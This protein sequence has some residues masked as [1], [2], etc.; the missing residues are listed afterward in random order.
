VRLWGKIF[1]SK[2]N[3]I[4]VETEFR[5]G[6]VEEE[7]QTPNAETAANEAEAEADTEDP[8][9]GAP[10]PKSKQVKKLSVEKQS[11]VNK[12]IYF[13]CSYGNFN[14]VNI[15]AGGEWT[16]LPDVIPEKLQV[17]RQINKMFTGDLQTRIHSYPVFDGDEAQYLRCQIARISAATVISPSNYYIP[18][19]EEAESDSA[20]TNPPIIINAE[21]EG[22]SNEQ[23]LL[24]SN[25]VHHVP[26]ILPQ[27]R[28]NWENPFVSKRD[29]EDEEAEEDE[30][31]EEEEEARIEPETGPA[32]LSAINVDDGIWYYYTKTIDLGN[33]PAW[34]SRLCS[35]LSPNNFSPVVLKS[36]RWI[37]ATVVSYNDKFTNIYMG[38]GLKNLGN[39]TP[40]F[41]P[42]LLPPV[43]SEF[44]VPEDSNLDE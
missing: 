40:I 14:I 42:P 26:Y 24:T 2:A 12:Y 36:N 41:S 15:L 32:I 30:E 16:K 6:A 7:E 38:N 20:G 43:Q 31:K 22:L 18:D 1:G 35:S 21:Y 27:G 44:E 5:E 33:L 19:P 13:V 3:Y 4:I 8:E 39:P 34:S 10:K 37:G 23:L 17:S 25:W 28:V 11:G 29:N 9:K